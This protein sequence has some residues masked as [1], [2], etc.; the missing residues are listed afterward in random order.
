[1]RTI[2]CNRLF[3]LLVLCLLIGFG[4]LQA[5]NSESLVRSKTNINSDWN[6]LENDAKKLAEINNN[7]G[8]VAVNLPH[9]WNSQ[10]AT[11]AEPGYRR[12][13]SWYKKKLTIPNIDSNK[14]YQLYFEGANIT[15]KVYVNGS[16]VGEH[17]GGY[18]GFTFDITKF[19]KAGNNE[20]LVR[21]DNSYNIDIIPSQ[22]SDFFIHGGIN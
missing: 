17:V 9:T 1:M 20:I 22:K 18:V 6:Y 14:V 12:S 8:W 13:A 4:S 21:V 19:I 2:F 3:H 5:Q 11:D 7:L 16:E 15:T 10:D